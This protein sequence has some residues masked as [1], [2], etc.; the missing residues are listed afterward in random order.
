VTIFEHT[1]VG[2]SL[3]LAAGAHRRHGWGVVAM[4]GLA[5]GLCD[6]DGLSLLFGAGAYARVHRVWAHNLLVAVVLGVL[7]GA[8]GYRFR[9]SSQG[10]RFAVALTARFV[11]GA[12]PGPFPGYSAQ[13][14]G[15]WVMLG[16]LASL[17]HLPADLVYAG[18]PD[19]PTWPVPLLWPFSDRG[20]A[21]P[22]VPWGDLGATL[23]LV[24]EMFALYRWP[25]YAQP[26]ACLALTAVGAYV[27]VWWLLKG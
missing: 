15:V 13:A 18:H 4:A 8:L 6:W 11:P 10:R 3:A 25:A 5:G 2:V 26:L 20:W 23:L 19:L 14:L 17:S 7:A 1:M 24:G 22:V 16:V 9:V 12:T 27:G 21:W